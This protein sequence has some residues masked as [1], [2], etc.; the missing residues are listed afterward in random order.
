MLFGQ[1]WGEP[2]YG[3]NTS[4]VQGFAA[5]PDDV[6]LAGSALLS[7]PG[8]NDLCYAL[9]RPARTEAPRETRLCAYDTTL[10]A[11][12]QAPPQQLLYLLVGG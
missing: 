2:W 7:V 8:P 4:L 12:F 5:C 10:K 11:L 9:T 1:S 3:E 6:E